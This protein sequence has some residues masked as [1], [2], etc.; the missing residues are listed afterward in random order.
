M[1]TSRC[2]F[3]FIQ[4]KKVENMRKLSTKTSILIA[5][6]VCK[7]EKNRILSVT[8][9]AVKHKYKLPPFQLFTPRNS[10][11]VFCNTKVQISPS[12]RWFHKPC[13]TIIHVA[14]T[15]LLYK[16]EQIP[17]LVKRTKKI[18]PQ[19]HTPELIFNPLALLTSVIFLIIL[20]LEKW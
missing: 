4:L 18:N 7:L 12:P 1:L 6:I 5:T 11:F 14:T 15:V 17:E 3:S 9:F 20:L 16:R 13:Y 8:L 2:D 19:P 10:T